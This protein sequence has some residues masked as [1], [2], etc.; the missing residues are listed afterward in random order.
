MSD[1]TPETCSHPGWLHIGIERYCA[2]CG[3][4]RDELSTEEAGDV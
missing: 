2:A 1:T 4:D 3:V